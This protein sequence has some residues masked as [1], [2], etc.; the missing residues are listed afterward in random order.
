M[1]KKKV[2]CSICQDQKHVFENGSYKRCDCLTKNALDLALVRAG[3]NT[4]SDRLTFSYLT[5]NYPIN[6]A[7]AKAV[8]EKCLSLKKGIFPEH[9][10]C[11]Q[12]SAESGAKE[13][14]AQLFI[15]SSLEAGFKSK[16][17]SISTLISGQFEDKVLL[18]QEF[19]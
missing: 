11:L 18:S 9:R 8:E 10:L 6:P 1:E 19:N 7:I 17:T 2:N 13:V 5:K 4:S 14:L 3:V 12:G 15:K 16:L